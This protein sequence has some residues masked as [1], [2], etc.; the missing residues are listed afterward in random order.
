MALFTFSK[1]DQEL[2]KSAMF[3]DSLVSSFFCNCE[4]DGDSSMMLFV[5]QAIWRKSSSNLFQTS[6]DSSNMALFT[7]SK[8]DQELVKKGSSK[9]KS[10]MVTGT[11][12]AIL[13]L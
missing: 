3:E 7:F 8:S 13:M 9:K 2:A 12:L 4:A 6:L 11:L 1:S 5:M 10:L